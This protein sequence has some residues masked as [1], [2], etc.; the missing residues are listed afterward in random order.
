MSFQQQTVGNRYWSGVLLLVLF[1]VLYLEEKK[2]HKVK[3]KHPNCRNNCRYNI[4]FCGFDFQDIARYS[5]CVWRVQNPDHY[6]LFIFILFKISRNFAMFPVF[7]FLLD[8]TYK[9]K[10]K[11]T[12]VQSWRNNIHNQVLI[13]S[14]CSAYCKCCFIFAFKLVY[15]LVT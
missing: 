11:C 4:I 9:K 15:I 6:Q 1:S 5:S 12:K 10:C 13:F 3:L 8:F 2:C 7:P 14:E